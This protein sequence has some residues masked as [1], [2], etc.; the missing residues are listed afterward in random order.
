MDSAYHLGGDRGNSLPV[1]GH[2][3]DHRRGDE[4]PTLGHGKMGDED[5]PEGGSVES[6]DR[7][8]RSRTSENKLVF[9]NYFVA[10]RHYVPRICKI[11][12]GVGGVA[13]Q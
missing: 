5:V 9:R 11:C 7:S 4:S 2:R 1:P 12:G 10:F 13:G 3:D 8:D 6:P